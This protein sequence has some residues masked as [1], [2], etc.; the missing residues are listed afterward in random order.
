[1]RTTIT[2]QEQL[3]NTNDPKVKEELEEQLEY[4]ESFNDT[5][6][7]NRM[8]DAVSYGLIDGFSEII[9]YKIILGGSLALFGVAIVMMREKNKKLPGSP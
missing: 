9:S 5:T 8:V 4:Y 2:I 1:M 6:R 7:F 3:Q